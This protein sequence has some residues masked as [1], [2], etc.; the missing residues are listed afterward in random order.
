MYS[1]S[2]IIPIYNAEK[3]IKK[4]LDSICNQTLNNVEIIC[5]N[6]GST[7][8]SLKILNKYASK[9]NRI[10]VIST[11]NNGQGSARNIGL[12]E[13]K[14]EYIGF[15][16]ADD[17]VTSNAFE[18]LYNKAKSFDLD[19]VFF[20]MV[21]Y[22]ENTKKFIETDL[23]NHKCFDNHGIT[24]SSIFNS[25][26]TKEFLFEIPVCPVSK[27]YKRSFLNSNNIR[28][29][30]KM[31]FE[32]NEMFYRT[33][34]KCGRTGFLKRKLYFRR[35]HE[36]SVTQTFDK[37][38]FDIIYAAN[39]VLDLFI[40]ENK[41]LQYKQDL[42]N[43]SFLMVMEWFKKS[44]LYIKQ[45]FYY[46]IKN[47]FRGFSDL[48][49][50]FKD[51]L[52]EENL[53][54]YNLISKNDSYL[55][56][57]SEYRLFTAEYSIFDNNKYFE[58][59]S[60]EYEDYK[61]N[62]CEDY[63]LSIVIPIHNNDLLINRTLM[64]I[65][66]QTIGVENLEVI[67]VNDDSTDNTLEI[68]NDYANKYDGFKAIHIKQG[69]GSPG[70]PR[71][72]GLLESS[73]DYVI[74][75]DHDDY[76]DLNAL[77][78]LYCS[79]IEKNCD[80]VYGTYVSIDYGIPTKIIYPNEYHGFFENINKNERSIAFPPP[81]IWTRLFRRDFLIDNNIL[82]PPIL[83]EDAIFIS[84]ALI[85]AKNINYLWNSLIC[86][87]NLDKNSYT[88]NVS[89]KYLEEGFVSEDYLFNFYNKIGNENFCRIR[90]E[91]ILDFY[92]TQFYKSNLTKEEIFRI[93]PLLYD[94]VYRFSLLGLYPH[95]SETNCI[96]FDNILDKNLDF[97]LKFK[98]DSTKIN[99]INTFK[100]LAKKFAKKLLKK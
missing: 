13:A 21:N 23:Y 35:R 84:K 86:Y 75:L 67:M 72:I 42:I 20:Q 17:W 28:F 18:L 5:V 9:D 26:N 92:L 59:G 8:N 97:I 100:L 24:E 10:K 46:L 54:I 38:K 52:Y 63:K 64:S 82:F 14:G 80:L 68:I 47:E 4:C 87:H 60:K 74:F 65:E 31:L 76:F 43:H 39:S 27:L 34:F 22:I 32:D 48:N 11:I 66:M 7:D 33:Y 37:S 40:K 93:F 36:G 55:D 73:S 62:S 6:D 3:Y 29:P 94:F 79:I 90:G 58:K 44:Y 71:N 25:H 89:Y 70:T 69:T 45:E 95:T 99:K 91:G 30:E 15:V 56:F 50:D 78:T 41:Y 19:M 85:K 96:L 1:V 81:S 16:D 83:G 49:F 88:N 61:L 51:N 98:K 77:N 57:L 12:N 2:I 53:L